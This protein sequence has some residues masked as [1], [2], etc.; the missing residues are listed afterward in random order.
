MQGEVFKGNLALLHRSQ[1][2]TGC[3]GVLVLYS[4]LLSPWVLAYV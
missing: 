2:Y 4:G 1:Y 3:E